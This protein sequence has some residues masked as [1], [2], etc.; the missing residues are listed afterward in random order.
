MTGSTDA[1]A[2][3]RE[4][5][6]DQ[7]PEEPRLGALSVLLTYHELIRSLTFRDIRARYKQSI[8]GVAWALIQPLALMVVYTV[9]FSLIVRVNTGGIPYPI[10]S[11]IALLPWTFFSGALTTSTESLVA[12]FNLVTKIYFPREAFPIA[13]VLGKMVDLGLGVL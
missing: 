9:V 13:G 11:Y 3:S 12:N 2:A 8:L 1:L 4:A 5:S 7:W 6:E 10:F